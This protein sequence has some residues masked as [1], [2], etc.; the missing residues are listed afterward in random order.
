[1]DTCEAQYAPYAPYTYSP[2]RFGPG[3]LTG[4]WGAYPGLAAAQRQSTLY[5]NYEANR[6]QAIRTNTIQHHNMNQFLMQRAQ[7]MTPTTTTRA[8]AENW[9]LNRQPMRVQW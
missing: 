6:R 4:S 2:Y 9:M 8:S 5:D 3:Y 1:V 7:T